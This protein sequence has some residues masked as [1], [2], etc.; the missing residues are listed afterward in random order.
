MTTQAADFDPIKFKE[1]TRQQWE[2]VAEAWNRWGPTLQIWLDPATEAVPP[3]L[4]LRLRRRHERG[5]RRRRHR[6]R[7]AGGIPQPG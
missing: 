3:A 4:P 5:A 7:P 1:S 2:N 6:E